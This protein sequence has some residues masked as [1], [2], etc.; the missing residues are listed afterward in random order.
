MFEMS[1]QHGTQSGISPCSTA[2]S[3]SLDVIVFLPEIERLGM[4]SAGADIPERS[5]PVEMLRV[6]SIPWLHDSCLRFQRAM[7]ILG[8]AERESNSGLNEK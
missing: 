1:G 4:S 7:G 2:S 6:C 5:E 3:R 8:R